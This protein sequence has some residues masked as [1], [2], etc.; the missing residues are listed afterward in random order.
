MNCSA[1]EKC[2]LT[3]QS[4]NF[5]NMDP[6]LTKPVPIERSFQ[7]LSN[8][9][10]FVKNGSI[11]TKLLDFKIN[12]HFSWAEQF[13]SKSLCYNSFLR[14]VYSKSGLRKSDFG[15]EPSDHLVTF[16][17]K[18]IRGLTPVG[19]HCHQGHYRELL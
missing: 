3:L 12:T 2:V 17:I 10:G 11:S 19:Q 18:V 5:V 9:T 1:H 7:S 6:F 15:T 13:N 14:Q 8:G 16:G 4:N